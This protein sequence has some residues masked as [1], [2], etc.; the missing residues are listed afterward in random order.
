[1]VQIKYPWWV[2]ISL[3]GFSKKKHLVITL[4]IGLLVNTSLF[5]FK[6]FPL[7]FVVLACNILMYFSIRWV[8]KKGNWSDI[9]NHWPS[10]FELIF[11]F[12]LMWI[13]YFLLKYFLI[14][15]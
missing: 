5:V 3:L 11:G 4:L 8:D 14:N 15:T 13:L 12:V 1:M 10:G 9:R 2:K 6:E 7:A